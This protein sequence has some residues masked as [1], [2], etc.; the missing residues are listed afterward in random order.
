MRTEQ[1]RGTNRIVNGYI[2][3][4]FSGIMRDDAV[5]RMWDFHTNIFVLTEILFGSD[6]GEEVYG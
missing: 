5:F 2:L 6:L 1:R 3:F 4:T